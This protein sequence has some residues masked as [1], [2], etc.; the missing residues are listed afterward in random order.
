MKIFL[1]GLPGVGK[2]TIGKKLATCYSIPALDLDEEIEKKE[3]KT[4]TEIF[5]QNG[6]DYFRKIEFDL[7]RDLCNSSDSFVLS[8]G[9]GTPAIEGA[10]NL[11]NQSGVSIY[12]KDSIDAIST[13]LQQ[14]TDSRPLLSNL[15]LPGIQLKLSD[16]LNSRHEYYEQTHIIT[17]VEV[18]SHL[19]LLTNRV[20]LFTK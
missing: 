11:I 8:L 2:T 5:S 1:V 18:S 19:H 17:G 10:M 3:G 6:E 12:L 9:G 15:D 4:V 16:L 20:E 13:R 7:L 14:N